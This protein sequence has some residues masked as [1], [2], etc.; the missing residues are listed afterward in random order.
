MKKKLAFSWLSAFK[1]TFCTSKDASSFPSQLPKIKEK[2]SS[3]SCLSPEE[4]RVLSTAETPQVHRLLHKRC[5]IESAA[6]KIQAAFRGYLARRALKSLKALVR[7][8]ALVRGC[9]IRRRTQVT[10]RCLFSLLRIQGRA[11]R[12]RLMDS[13]G[14]ISAEENNRLYAGFHR[15]LMADLSTQMDHDRD[16]TKTSQYSKST[17]EVML[18]NYFEK[19]GETEKISGPSNKS[20]IREQPYLA[21][22]NM[23]YPKIDKDLLS[24]ETEVN[25]RRHPRM[26]LSH[27][28]SSLHQQP[29]SSLK[30]KPR[31]RNPNRIQVSEDWH[32]ISPPAGAPNYMAFTESAKARVTTRVTSS[33][34]LST[35]NSPSKMKL[36]K[37]SFLPPIRTRRSSFPLVER[38]LADTTPSSGG[39]CRRRARHSTSYLM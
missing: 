10:L 25:K 32:Q 23:N 37:G 31:C 35:A 27:P 34:S 5:R 18:E 24:V 19:N 15:E 4:T 20:F 30:T 11:R 7:L 36:H 26:L 22:S 39:E 8:Q 9:Y 1:K 6:T 21:I 3:S 38:D 13:P 33:S 28:H 12:R 16:S 2:N 29:F 14:I 17:T